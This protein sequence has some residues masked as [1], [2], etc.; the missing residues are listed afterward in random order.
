MMKITMFYRFQYLRTLN[1]FFSKYT[2]LLYFKT[3]ADVM[4]YLNLS[5]QSSGYSQQYEPGVEPTIANHFSAA[6][7]RFAHT[8]LPLSIY[9]FF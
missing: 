6:A 2:Y 9:T 3:G 5:V 7:F 1:R 4:L 8:L